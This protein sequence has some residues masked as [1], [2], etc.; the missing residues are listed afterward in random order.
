MLK[1][2]RKQYTSFGIERQ[3]VLPLNTEFLIPDD[4]PVRLLD[5]VLEELNYTE[6]YL[7]YSAQ[8]RNPSADP[9]ALF[10]VFIYAYS[11]G[12]TSSRGIED[13]CRYDVRYHYL[14]QSRKAPDHNTIN[15]FRREHLNGV[16]LENLF[17]QFI[18]HLMAM[19]EISLAELFIDG[20]KIEANA[21]RY[22]FVWRGSVEKN[23][24]K[25]KEK[26]SSWLAEELSV[27]IPPKEI[28]A[29]SLGNFFRKIRKKV[30]REGVIFVYGVGR[31]K[32]ELQRQYETL[33]E[34]TKRASFYEEA[35]LIMGEGRN[36]YS[37]TDPDATFMHMK[38][39]HM[40]NAQLKPGYN[41]QVATNSEYI[42]GI[43]VSNDR[44]DYGTLIPFL[45]KLSSMY[46][47]PIG[48]LV[49]D[50][51]YESEENYDYLKRHNISS[52]IKPSNH[53]YSKTRA[54]QRQ[55]EFRLSMKY[56][57]ARD[58]YT[59]KYGKCLY[60]KTTRIKTSYSGYKSETK[61]YECEDCS[62]CPY[63]GKCYKGKYRKQIQVS[64]TFDAYRQE[65]ERNI[66]SEEGVLL[67]VNRSIQA[68]GVFGITKQDMG[69]TRFRTRGISMVT[70]E[71]LLLAFGF[72]VNKLHNRIQN[73]RFGNPLLIPKKK[74]QVA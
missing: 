7:T 3:L 11:Q 61:V 60:Y 42:L 54:Y 55:M 46:M 39:D 41:V 38:E 9:K 1:L 26:A 33:E 31:K 27:D 72:N 71:Y 47:R 22:T 29:D 45:K 48:R 23:Y 14:L 37:K 53:E 34:Y 49:C 32:T 40:R 70:T 59:C 5:Q 12:I 66:S 62:G 6:L 21:G 50:A 15:R 51:G 10:K 58:C 56:D 28:D 43:H 20:T 52:F 4:E 36:S 2:L 63:L 17:S 16:V 44:T 65:S 19:G 25:M 73:N 30:K 57:E 8:G 13:A 74:V 64:P 68:E 24:E 18:E 35:L 67:R 69:F